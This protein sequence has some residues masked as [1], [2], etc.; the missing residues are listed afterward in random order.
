MKRN[1]IV[2]ALILL[3][4]CLT[5]CS[6]VFDAAISGSVKDSS[7]SN[8]SSSGAIADAMVYAYDSESAMNSAYSSYMADFEAGNRYVFY[9]NSVPSAKTAADGSFSIST[10]RWKTNNPYYGKDA[11]SKHV[12]LLVFHKDYGLNRVPG[13]IVQSDKSN[14]FGVVY[15]TK[16]RTSKNLVIN[17]KDLEH[18]G[19][20]SDN[21]SS[22]SGFSYRYSYNDGYEVVSDTINNVANGTS[23][24]VVKYMIEDPVPTV[25]I[26]D[27]QSDSD[28]TYKDKG[29][30]TVVMEY[31][32]ASQSYKN[33]SLY[34]TNDW[35]TVAVT[36]NLKDG[37]STN[38]DSN[39]SDSID[40][41]WKYNNGESDKTDTITVSNGTAVISVKY[42]KTASSECKLTLSGFA[43]STETKDNWGR[44]KSADN[45]T[46]VESGNDAV[47]FTVDGTKDSV[48]YNVYFKKKV[49]VIPATG[50][51]GYAVD[52]IGD[53]TGYGKSS[54]NG[55]TIGLFKDSVADGNKIGKNVYTNPNNV[56]STGTTITYNGHFTGLAVNERIALTYTDADSYVS[57]PVHLHL[58]IIKAGES[59]FSKIKAIDVDST[60]TDF[61]LSVIVY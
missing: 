55:R 24:L 43:A 42:K 28:W 23:T 8:S 7:S 53:G 54:D 13:R 45:G 36:V 6:S 25:T 33:N 51:S 1:L 50:F 44:T 4:L 47:E 15:L 41:T 2:T 5:G 39:I 32:M 37:S 61:D 16:T 58:G 56:T 31:D 10:L 22:T 17:F 20:G 11:D 26:S 57:D 18:T 40:L 60:T 14:N 27:I 48:S 3:V 52:D 29:A 34:F 35:K 9:D 46:F 12:Y 30:K 38:Q 59:A 19:N 21:I 49:L